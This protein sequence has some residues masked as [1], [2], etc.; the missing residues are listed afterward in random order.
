MKIFT[1]Y[2]Y[3]QTIT[4]VATGQVSFVTAIISMLTQFIV[5]ATHVT[6]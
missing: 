4:Q 6:I 5:T 3:T 1:K 2:K